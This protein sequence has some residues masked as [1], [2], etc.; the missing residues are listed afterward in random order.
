ML[1]FSFPFFSF[2]FL[3]TSLAFLALQVLQ[4]VLAVFR[5]VCNLA[6]Q[7]DGCMMPAWSKRMNRFNAPVYKAHAGTWC[8]DSVLY[9]LQARAR[10]R[11]PGVRI[12]LMPPDPIKIQLTTANIAGR[13]AIDV[14]RS[15]TVDLMCW[16]RSTGA[17]PTL[18]CQPPRGELTAGP[19]ARVSLPP[20]VA[21][22]VPLLPVLPRSIKLCCPCSIG[23]IHQH[24]EAELL[25]SMPS[26]PHSIII[27]SNILATHSL[28]NTTTRRIRNRPAVAYSPRDK[29]LHLQLLL[30][31]STD[32][33]A[34]LVLDLVVKLPAPS[35]TAMR[36]R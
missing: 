22:Q 10:C 11:C 25:C 32:K 18:N 26:H 27:L 20:V 14:N 7:T 12:D 1:C 33:S 3:C 34:A 13:Q 31:D 28:L 21:Q 15:T 24:V 29:Q 16:N 19:T 35:R 2:L 4:V 17:G 5:A 9:Q 36:R 8:E 6:A 23:C 30:P